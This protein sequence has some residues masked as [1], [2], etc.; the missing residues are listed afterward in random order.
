M[1]RQSEAWYAPVCD[2]LSDHAAADVEC[3]WVQISSSS[4]YQ[5]KQ[6][7]FNNEK[8]FMV[9]GDLLATALAAACKAGMTDGAHRIDLEIA[10]THGTQ[11]GEQCSQCCEELHRQ[12]CLHSG[13]I[14][15]LTVGPWAMQIVKMGQERTKRELMELCKQAGAVIFYRMPPDSKAEIADLTK[16]YTRA[17][18]CNSC[19]KVTAVQSR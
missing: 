5:N 15:L 18:T 4:G 13:S 14:N 12:C 17:E 2:R 8:M 16:R 9:T 19:S 7:P 11:D 1:Q 3:V 10:C 6:G